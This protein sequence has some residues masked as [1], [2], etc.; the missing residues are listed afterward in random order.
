MPIAGL[1]AAVSKGKSPSEALKE[2][3]AQV[4]TAFLQRV[5]RG[6]TPKAE[7]PEASPEDHAAAQPWSDS[8]S[9]DS[10]TNDS[11]AFFETP[12]SPKAGSASARF[13]V[14]K[15]PK[16]FNTKLFIP[17]GVGVGL[18]FLLCCGVLSIQN[19]G[20]SRPGGQTGLT[21]V[22]VGERELR[23]ISSPIKISERLTI[24]ENS[25]YLW[26]TKGVGLPWTKDGTGTCSI[27][28]HIGLRTVEFKSTTGQTPG[29]PPYTGTFYYSG[30]YD[31]ILRCVSDGGDLSYY[32]HRP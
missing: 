24:Y 2:A 27:G 22:W 31:P 32:F 4:G 23:G 6:L 29:L 12:Q 16:A 17:L 5:K 1:T 3:A 26:E 8:D 7:S 19:G 20:L 11:L 25:T 9:A 13:K 15:K 14:K 30:S 28:E 10:P 21:G 18:L